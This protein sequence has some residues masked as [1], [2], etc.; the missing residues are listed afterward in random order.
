[1]G[2]L[3][4]LS[5]PAKQGDFSTLAFYTCAQA[6]TAF[7]NMLLSLSPRLGLGLNP[8]CPKQMVSQRPDK[9]TC[10]MNLLLDFPILK[11]GLAL[12]HGPLT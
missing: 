9:L 6:M 3:E 5:S 10:T 11:R 12:S 1:M 2:A 7:I 8:Y 4:D